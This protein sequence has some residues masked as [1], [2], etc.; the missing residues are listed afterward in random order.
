M[1]LLVDK[2]KGI[3]SHGVVGK[4]RKITG[5]R[6]IGHAGTLDPNATGL[7]VVG[8]GRAST[9]RLEIFLKKDKQYI[10]DIVLGIGTDTD[11]IL[12][13]VIAE[14]KNTKPSYTEVAKVLEGFIG[15]QTQLPP[16]YSAIKIKGRTAYKIARLGEVVEMKPRKI[17]IFN[18][19]L[20]SYK[21][22]HVKIDLDVSSGTYIRAFA[23]DFGL[24]LGTVAALSDLRRTK[25][26]S[27]DVKNAVLLSELTHDNWKNYVFDI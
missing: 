27:F 21:F 6:R 10:A 1:F 9:K 5:V 13:K 20:L 4:L 25:I 11:D 2:P 19:H 24:C 8:V 12:G 3:S 15:I 17:E 7:L 18:L 16:K 22:P 23:R 14:N 26:G